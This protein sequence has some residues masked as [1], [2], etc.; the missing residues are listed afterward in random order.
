[1]WLLGN[2]IALGLFTL[3][4]CGA[5]YYTNYKTSKFDKFTGGPNGTHFCRYCSSPVG[6]R[7][8]GFEYLDTNFRE[9]DQEEKMPPNVFKFKNKD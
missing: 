3:V 1:M 4:C 7:K 8:N 2:L 9:R 6:F 5:I